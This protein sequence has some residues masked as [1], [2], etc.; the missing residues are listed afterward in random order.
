MAVSLI[1]LNVKGLSEEGPRSPLKVH[2]KKSKFEN[3]PSQYA[4]TIKQVEN[5]LI[6]SR[7][8]QFLKGRAYVGRS[9]V[10][11]PPPN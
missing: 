6:K 10:E 8:I 5:I 2:S 4:L 1:P 3:I 11:N 7:T 9:P